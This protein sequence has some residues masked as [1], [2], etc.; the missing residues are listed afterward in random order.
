[1]TRSKSVRARLLVVDDDPGMHTLVHDLV[2]NESTSIISAMTLAEGLRIASLQRVD[3]VLLDHL[4]PDGEGLDRIADFIAHDRLLPILYVTAQAGSKTAIEAIK[5][6][7]FEYLSKPIDFKLL[8]QRIAEAIEYRRLTRLPVLV[9][10]LTSK[11]TDS[12]ILVGRCRGMQEVYK[13]IGRFSTLRTPILIE[14]EVGTGKEMIA[15]AI[16]QNGPCASGPFRK[17]SSKEFGDAELQIEL[18]GG[19]YA[20][21]SAILNCGGGTLMID[22]IDNG[23][24]ATQSRLLRFFQSHSIDGVSADTR[25]IL[26]TSFKVRDLVQSGKLRNDLF[27]YLSPYVIRVPALRERQG[28]LELLV[29]HFMQRIAHVSSTQKEQGPPRVSSNAMQLLNDYDWPGNIAELKS[30][31]QGV[32]TESRGAVLATDSLVRFLDLGRAT[33]F[34]FNT[35][36]SNS[37]TVPAAVQETSINKSH[38]GQ[39]WDLRAFV[40]QQVALGTERLYDQAI[41]LLDEKLLH[42]IMQHTNGNRLRAAKLLGITRTSLRRKMNGTLQVEMG[43]ESSSELRP[44]DEH[45]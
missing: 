41:A 14:G 2:D 6:G 11:E 18:F 36:Q 15:R 22:D 10:S 27:Y 35:R 37:K 19:G 7:A 33:A 5:R 26:A 23:S 45:A 4:L 30:V 38:P 8:R 9:D 24:V 1:M 31:L 42:L 40:D 32:L 34:D 39:T 17:I 29:S 43:A 16:H 25:I 3:V 21:P 12:D 28:D 20:K 44:D 13:S